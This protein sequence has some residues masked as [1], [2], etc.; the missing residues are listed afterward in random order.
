MSTTLKAIGL[1]FVNLL[2]VV[3]SLVFVWW[4]ML[5]IA[6]V[7]D[8]SV[9]G[10]DQVLSMLLTNGEV[11]VGNGESARVWSAVLPPLGQTL[12]DAGL[13]FVAGLAAAAAI[14]AGTYLS[15]GVEAATMPVAVVIRT[16]PLVALAPVITL[17][18]G[19]G[20]VT[21]AVMS[22]IVVLF[23]ALVNISLGLR[24]VSQQMH[25]VVTVYGGSDVDVLRR[26]GFPSALPAIFAAI[27]ISVPGAITGAL[28][29]EFYTTTDSV[30][31]AVNQALALYLYDYVWAILVVVTVASILLYIAAQIIE[32]IVLSRFAMTDALT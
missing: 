2:V 22:G 23:P 27:R 18:F 32:R 1:P 9:R 11:K 3:V 15:R 17:I 19:N 14:A 16:V 20:F 5:E 29:A 13:G 10:P 7:P 25:D 4:V 30:G 26:V 28:I 12:F 31:K 24:S 6:D 21:V 8:F